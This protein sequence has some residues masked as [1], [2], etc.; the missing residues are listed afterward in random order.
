MWG[1]LVD[2]MGLTVGEGREG[3]R[4]GGKGGGREG[5]VDGDVGCCLLMSRASRSEER[6]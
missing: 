3:W 4:E 2:G 5:R 6:S 1:C